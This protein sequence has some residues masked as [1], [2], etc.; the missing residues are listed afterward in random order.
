MVLEAI[1]TSNIRI[2]NKPTPNV[3]LAF[4]NSEKMYYISI[5]ICL[6]HLITA[7]I[8][9]LSILSSARQII[10]VCEK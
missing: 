5:Y 7:E 2:I 3:L 6:L 9:D 8:M 10:S 1:D 4:N